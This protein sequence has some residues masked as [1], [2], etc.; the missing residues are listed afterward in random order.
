MGERES[1]S[2]MQ[3]CPGDL[4]AALCACLHTRLTI[5]SS[6]RRWSAILGGSSGCETTPAGL[7]LLH[8]TSEACST[9]RGV[10]MCWHCSNTRPPLAGPPPTLGLVERRAP[11]D[12][13]FP[14]VRRPHQQQA[15]QAGRRGGANTRGMLEQHAHAHPLLLPVLMLLD[16][17]EN[18]CQLQA[19][20]QTSRH[21]PS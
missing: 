6:S 11:A 10:V 5:T 8:C 12:C 19:E 13:R 9:T 1:A 4:A 18:N 7:L 15:R 14:L 3:A 17:K 21:K 16:W 2:V 20:R